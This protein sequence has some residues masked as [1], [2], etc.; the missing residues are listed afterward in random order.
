MGPNI[1]ET[2]NSNHIDISYKTEGWEINTLDTVRLAVK[3]ML[4]HYK[5]SVV[6]LLVKR[7]HRQTQPKNF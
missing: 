5:S 6:F 3:Q 2:V 1:F 7:E 4:L